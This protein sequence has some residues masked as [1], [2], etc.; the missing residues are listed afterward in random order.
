MCEIYVS[1][2]EMYD[3]E[4]QQQVVIVSFHFVRFILWLHMTVVP[5]L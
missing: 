5:S 1:N 2:C 4:Q 3:T